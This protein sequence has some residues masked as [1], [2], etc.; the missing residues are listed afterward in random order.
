MEGIISHGPISP[1]EDVVGVAGVNYQV[2]ILETRFQVMKNCGWIAAFIDGMMMGYP[3]LDLL[4]FP[5]YATTLDGPDVAVISAACRRNKVW[6]IF[7]LTGEAHPEGLNPFNTL[8]MINDKGEKALT[9]RKI[10]PWVPME[11]W[12]AGHET[13]VAEGP[14]VLM[15]A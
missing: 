10:F 9:Y 13:V 7:S 2:P 1:S 3:G 14:K 5:D 8:I 4:I 11:P 6:G 15:V 12:T